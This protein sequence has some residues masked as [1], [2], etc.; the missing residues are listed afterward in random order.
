MGGFLF[1]RID[2]S[3]Y[4][5]EEGIQLNDAEIK[6]VLG[7]MFDS[8]TKG[9]TSTGGSR[10]AGSKSGCFADRNSQHRAIFFKDAESFFQYHEM[11]ARNPSIVGTMMDHVRSMASDTALLEQMGPSLT[12][13]FIPYTTRQ[14]RKHQSTWH[15]QRARG[16]TKMYTV[17]VLSLSKTCGPI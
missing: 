16:D 9:K 7:S 3:R 15:K 10:V 11:F 4:V 13:L 12:P 6:D 8:I 17:L 2:K 1:D 14:K 5:D